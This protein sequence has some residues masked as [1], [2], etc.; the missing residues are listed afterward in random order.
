MSKVITPPQKECFDL[1]KKYQ[2]QHGFT[3]TYK[4][5]GDMM[6][7]S[8]QGVKFHLVALEKKG[9]LKTNRQN[10]SIEILREV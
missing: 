9:V 5:L 6:G 10:R 8:P 3:P 7:I 4:E 2:E 1:I